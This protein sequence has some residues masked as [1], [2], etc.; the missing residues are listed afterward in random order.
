VF[1]TLGRV[2][3]VGDVVRAPGFGG[4]MQLRVEE[5]DERRVSRLRLTSPVEEQQGIGNRE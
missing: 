3:E 4:G 2:P 5:T 1:G